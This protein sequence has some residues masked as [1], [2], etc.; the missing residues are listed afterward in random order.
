[1]YFNIDRNIPTKLREQI[2]AVYFNSRR[3]TAEC[4]I[5]EKSL[6]DQLTPTLKM[7]VA[8]VVGESLIKEM[9]FFVGC[10]T[11]FVMDLYFLMIPS[12]FS[13]CET[14][15]AEQDTGQSMYKLYGLNV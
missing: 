4:K 10:N 14:V 6:F 1:M 8:D 15:V 13:P 2:R 5:G 11:Q 3:I 7:Q 9:N 12:C